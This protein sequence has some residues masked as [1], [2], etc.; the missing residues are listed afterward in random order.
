MAHNLLLRGLKLI[1]QGFGT[2]TN[3]HRFWVEKKSTCEV[4]PKCATLCTTVYDRREVNIIDE[5]LRE[6]A[7]VLKIQKRRFYCKACKKP[8]TEHVNGI[9]KRARVTERFRGYVFN[10]CERF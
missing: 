4:C 5:P 3:E 9:K 2:K 1:K 6:S 10:C 8:F 7:V